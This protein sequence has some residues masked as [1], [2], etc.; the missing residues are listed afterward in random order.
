MFVRVK[1]KPGTHRKTVQIVESVRNGRKVSQR[2]VRHVGVAENEAE[3][4]KLKELGEVLK[5]EAQCE[6]KP[7]VIPHENLA[8]LAIRALRAGNR[9]GPPVAIEETHEE[10]RV[11]TGFQE[12]YGVVYRQLGFDG[13]LPTERNR[14]AR[15]ALQRMVMARIANPDSKRSSAWRLETEL[16]ISIPVQRIYRTMD[17]L[18]D[19][20][21]ESMK[22]LAG[23]TTLSLLPEPESVAIFNYTMLN[24]ESVEGG[25]LRELGFSNNGLGDHTRLLLALMVKPDGL[26]ISYKV[27][28]GSER[29]GK[30]LIPALERM[31]EREGVETAI[32]VADR[33]LFGEE[34]LK[35]ME[36]WKH[37]YIVGARLKSLPKDLK[38]RILDLETYQPISGAEDS[39]SAEF[40]HEGRRIVVG[41]NRKRARKDAADRQKAVDKLIRKLNRSTDP[42]LV[43][44]GS[45]FGRFVKVEGEDRLKVDEDKI[46]K[47][48]RW[49]GL[50]GIIT[51]ALD[52]SHSELF[53]RYRELGRVKE[54]FRITKHDVKVRPVFQWNPERVKAHIA[55][56]YM[57]FACIRHLAYRVELQ[58][59]EWMSPE[60]VRTALAARQCSIMRDTRSKRRFAL[61]S[62]TTPEMERICRALGLPLSRAP[63]WID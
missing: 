62:N 8:E 35:D 15:E 53:A 36:E 39:R 49:D 1:S 30:G 37:Q 4:A 12:A 7:S 55:I 50:K 48:A 47:A 63:Y 21:I 32:H 26:P 2:I 23:G 34:N 56:S 61:L 6:R 45:S 46:K 28:P 18:D 41:W 14:T 58:Q 9:K 22:Y 60:T 10:H 13:L 57:A 24:F 40:E 59:K 51:N 25:S 20:V 16:G 52:M 42:E 44:S 29:E 11:V 54:N 43:L 5:A 19:K 33:D 38:E 3:L 31:R 17:R 27:F